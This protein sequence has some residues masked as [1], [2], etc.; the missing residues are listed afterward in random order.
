MVLFLTLTA[1]TLQTIV[2]N[3]GYVPNIIIVDL[4]GRNIT[5]AVNIS[6]DENDI[7]LESNVP[8]TGKLIYK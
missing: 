4:L 6:Q 1:V 7:I 2:H 5:D 3:L 8:I